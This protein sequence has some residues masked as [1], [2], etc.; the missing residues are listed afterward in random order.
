MSVMA[1]GKGSTTGNLQGDVVGVGLAADKFLPRLSTLTDDIHGVPSHSVSFE[2]AKHRLHNILLILAFARERELVLGLSVRD[3]VDPEPFIGSPEEA[4]KVSLDILDIYKWL[5]FHLY[6]ACRIGL[7]T[8][9]LGSKRVFLVNDDDLPVGLLL[10][11]EG[12]NAE[13]LHAFDLA[14]IGDQLSDLANIK[15]VIVT[16][17]LGLGVDGVG[18]FPGLCNY[19]VRVRTNGV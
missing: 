2:F 3:L 19:S 15:R 4:R 8:V 11:Q 10:V 9:E 7:Y 6:G 12:H 1:R 17:G 13:D 16:L 5:Q 18:V 14:G